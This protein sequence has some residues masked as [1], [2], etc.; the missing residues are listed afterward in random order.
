[1]N[2]PLVKTIS[3]YRKTAKSLSSFLYPIPGMI[4]PKTGR[5]HPHYAQNGAWS[6]RMSCWNPN[7][8]QI[9][10][11]AKFRACFIAPPGRKLIIADYSQI[12]LRVAAEI[13]RDPR[14]TEAYRKGDDLHRLTASLMLNKDM[15]MV[16]PQER[17][18]AKAVNFG[19]I[20]SMGAAGLKQYA[21]QSYGTEMTLEQAEEF[22]NRFFKAYTGIAKWHR[23]LKNEPPKESRT[24]AGRKFT[25]SENS[26]LAILSNTPVQGTA[27]DIAKKALGLLVNRLKNTNTHIMGVIHDEIIVESSDE[28]A[29]EAAEILKTTMEEAG[30]SILK[31]VPC[32]AE[33]SISQNWS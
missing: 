5:L 28:K 33:V 2:H 8:Q 15:N 14:M 32:Q 24:L 20:Y 16:A 7:I 26:G 25:F 3:A 19:L 4:H 17:Q 12:E 27:A 21:A 11:S 18:A 9:P 29:D 1:M 31:Y 13:T 10:R 6:G 30:N 22:R 23:T